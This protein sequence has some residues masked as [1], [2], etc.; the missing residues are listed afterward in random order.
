[1]VTYESVRAA[2]GREIRKQRKAVGFTQRELAARIRMSAA[3]IGRVERGAADVTAAEFVRIAI[4]LEADPM[5]LL[6]RVAGKRK[7]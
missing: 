4:A 5:K 1:M 6:R 3:Y 7:R 2:I